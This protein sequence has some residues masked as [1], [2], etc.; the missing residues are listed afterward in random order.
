MT[1]GRRPGTQKWSP[2]AGFVAIFWVAVTVNGAIMMW[3]WLRDGGVTQIHSASDLWTS[4]G[5]VT[6]LLGAYLALLQVLLLARLPPLER[7]IGFDRLTVWHRRNG[8]LVIYLVVAHVVLITIGY[9]G[10]VHI[11]VWKQFSEFLSTYPGMITATIGT[12]MMIAI[13]FSS[14]VIVRRRLPYEAWYGVHLTL[15]AAI[16]LAYLHQIPSGNEFLSSTSQSDWWIAMYVVTLAL[17]I[18][19]RVL[20]PAVGVFRYRLRVVEVRRETH[21]TVSVLIEGRQLGRLHQQAGQ[22]MLWRF[23]APKL[24]WQSHPFSLSAAPDGRQLRITVKAVGGYTR[25]LANLRPGTRVVTEGPFGRF[26]ASRRRHER[27][28]LIAGGIGVTPL[29]AIFEEL[30]AAP[31]MITFIHRVV[32]EADC[33]LRTELEALA[34]ERGAVLHYLIGDHRD[35]SAA[36]LLS[37]Q[38]LRRLVPEISNSDVFLCGPARMMEHTHESLDAA[39]VP[40]RQV[41]SERFALAA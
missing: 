31:G 29:R 10:G 3:L 40:R 24:W 38:N 17:A 16:F 14:L 30:S 28:T 9:A 18:I 22:F 5:R 15:Y 36:G 33:A 13:V 21:D 39:G 12:V 25:E 26:V 19:Y 41:H 8:K 34:A 27:V 7:Q 11:S 20:H 6:G 37:A 35:P 23:L 1:Q 4:G 32:A 2:S